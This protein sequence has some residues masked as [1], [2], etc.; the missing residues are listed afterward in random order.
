MEVQWLFIYIQNFLAKV[1]ATQYPRLS[2]YVPLPP[3]LHW[4]TVQSRIIFKLGTIAYQTLSSGEPSYLFSMLS[5]VSKPRQLRSS[6]FYLL[7]VPGVKTH[8][9][10]RA[11]LVAVP[12]LWNLLPEHI[13]P[14]NSIVSFRHYLKTQP[15]RL[16]YP[17]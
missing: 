8:A 7:S 16:A 6:G 3:S 5:L 17:S 1:A 4:L 12:T 2:H 10:T 14:S 9:R 15:F 13:K 11:F